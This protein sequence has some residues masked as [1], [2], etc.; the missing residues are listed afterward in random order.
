MRTVVHSGQVALPMSDWP[1]VFIPTH[2]HD[3]FIAL[4]VLEANQK[5]ATCQFASAM[6]RR[7]RSGSGGHAPKHQSDRSLSW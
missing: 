6:R 5:R 3:G 7:W 1:P 4:D 2:H